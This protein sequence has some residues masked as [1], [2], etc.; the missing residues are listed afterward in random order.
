MSAANSPS[1][2]ST[3]CSGTCRRAVFPFTFYSWNKESDVY[4]GWGWSDLSVEKLIVS[5]REEEDPIVDLQID[6]HSVLSCLQIASEPMTQRVDKKGLRWFTK[7]WVPRVAGSM[8]M[9]SHMWIRSRDLTALYPTK[10]T[11]ALAALIGSH[12]GSCQCAERRVKRLLAN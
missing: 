11:W 4:R 5:T 6:E 2:F 12:S 3:P 9:R 7:I 10:E 8:I 1:A